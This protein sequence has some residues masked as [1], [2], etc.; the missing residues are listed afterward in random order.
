MSEIRTATFRSQEPSQNLGG[1]IVVPRRRPD[2]ATASAPGRLHTQHLPAN[3]PTDDLSNAAVGSAHPVDQPPDFDL[4]E[5]VMTPL[6]HRRSRQAAQLTPHL[7]VGCLRH[8]KGNA[9]IIIQLPLRPVVDIGTRRQ[10]RQACVRTVSGRWLRHG[11]SRPAR[12]PSV[13]TSPPG[14]TGD[15]G[16]TV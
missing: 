6:G 4:L 11:W 12:S 16:Q 15:N 5:E 1:V 14:G 2:Q 8:L 3:A 9:R 13:K 7:H 10:E